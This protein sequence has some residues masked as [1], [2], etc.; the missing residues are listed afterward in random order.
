LSIGGLARGGVFLFTGSIIGSIL[1]YVF[2]FLV[3]YYGGVE[4]V[5]IA[6]SLVSLCSLVSGIAILGLPT[7]TKRFLG[8]EFG[9]NNTKKLNTY[10]WSSLA[11]TLTLSLVAALIIWILPFLHIRVLGFS[12][13]M[14]FFAGVIVLLS[15]STIIGSLFM[16]TTKTDSWAVSTVISAILKLGIGVYLVYLG[17]G[18][19][20]ALEGIVISN[21]FYLALMVL[22]ALRE[23]RRLGG[24]EVQFSGKAVRESLYAGAVAWLPGVI[25]LLGQQLGTLTVFGV[26][27]GFEAGTYFIAY[28]IFTIILMLPNSLNA[29]LF[30]ALSGLKVEDR[31]D[32][33]RRALKLCLALACP[34]TVFLAFYPELPLSIMGAQYLGASSTLSILVLSIIPIL[35]IFTVQSLVYAAGHYGKSIAMDLSTGVPQVILYF[36]LVP[37]YKGMGAALAYTI[38]ALT[39]S[40]AAMIISRLRHIRVPSGKI[41][42]AIVVPFAVAL[43]C[44][45]LKLDWWVTGTMILLSSIVSYGRM[46]VV[47]RSDLREIAQ[48]FASEKTIART[49]KRL[50]WLLRIIYGD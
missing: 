4:T 10:F 6:S 32:L 9:H 8:R 27:G 12:D 42:V 28:V 45:L 49:G 13:D 3:S 24:I 44:Y 5:G 41:I 46:G 48:A 38:G 23:L 30:P 1:G 20:G 14:L 29:I 22:F 11:T 16:S 26:Q 37:I 7:G 43:P 2:W 31:R 19:V 35:F 34:I 47:E 15:F 25:V 36:V 50:N 18:W 21:L 17:F 39:G 33:A 40:V